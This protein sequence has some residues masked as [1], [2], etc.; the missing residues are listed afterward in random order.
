MRKLLASAIAALAMASS[1]QAAPV[2]TVDVKTIRFTMPTVA[3]DLIEFVVPTKES[4]AGAPQFHEDEWRQLEFFPAARLVE[5]KRKLSELKAFEQAHRSPPGWSEIYARRLHPTVVLPGKGSVARIAQTVGAKHV[6]A[7]ILTTAS[8]PL[9]QVKGG[10]T[11]GLAGGV[12]LYGLTGDSGVG[13][14]AAMVRPDG[15]DME[16][17]RAFSALHQAHGLIL[18]DW[19]FQMLLVSVAPSGALDV[20][21]P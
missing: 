18:V 2:E 11:L 17:V 15:D 13:V 10:F 6:G 4:F 12:F 19:R 9:G 1:S 3:A 21:R 8:R 20:W 7:P 14:L 16:L 5:I